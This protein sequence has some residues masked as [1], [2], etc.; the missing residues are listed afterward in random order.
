MEK[1]NWEQTGLLEGLTGKT[2]EIVEMHFNEVNVDSLPQYDDE[3]LVETLIF[4]VIRRIIAVISSDNEFVQ[5]SLIADHV[6]GIT[7]DDV[8]SLI[9]VKEITELL[10][11]YAH[12]FIPYAEKYLPDLDAQAEMSLLFCNNYVMKLINRTGKWN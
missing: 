9:D 3:L 8:L 2:R 11:D 5:N 6:R 4:P 7:E 1:P 12:V 10:I